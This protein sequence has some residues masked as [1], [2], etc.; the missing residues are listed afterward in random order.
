MVLRPSGGATK[1]GPAG[2]NVSLVP[3]DDVDDTIDGALTAKPAL[4]S[5]V[6]VP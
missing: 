3:F 6:A 5:G 2:T 1:T 4:I